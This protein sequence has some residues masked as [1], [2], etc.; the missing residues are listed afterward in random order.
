MK[1]YKDF[2]TPEKGK[3]KAN[4]GLASFMNNSIHYKNKFIKKEKKKKNTT[5]KVRGNKREVQNTLFNLFE[6][7]K[8]WKLSDLVEKT[9]QPQR[10]LKKILEEICDY[11]KYGEHAEHWVIKEE[12]RTNI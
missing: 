3:M 5:K 1:T 7:H 2:N 12:W 11:E 9:Q 6:N 10:Y 4:H 8:Y